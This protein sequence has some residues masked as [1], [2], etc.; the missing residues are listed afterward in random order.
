MDQ[1]TSLE[2]ALWD[3]IGPPLYYCSDCLRAVKVRIE[4]FEALKDYHWAL[5]DLK[6]SKKK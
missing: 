6:R 1:R 2:R 3:Q 4:D 5:L